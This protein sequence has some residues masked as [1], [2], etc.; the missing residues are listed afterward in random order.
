M[1]PFS[2]G[3]THF[4]MFTPLY[5]ALLPLLLSLCFLLCSSLILASFSPSPLIVPLS[6][7]HLLLCPLLCSPSY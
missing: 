1:P 3:I 6:L 4:N 2:V 5:S 7:L